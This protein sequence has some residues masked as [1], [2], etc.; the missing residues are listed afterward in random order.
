MKSFWSAELDELK[1]ASINAHNLWVLYDTPRQGIINKIYDA[2]Y[3]YK[4]AI[5]HASMNESL[6][7]DDELSNHFLRK[8]MT[9][10]WRHWYTRFSKRNARPTKC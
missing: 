3:K 9:K 1:Q 10:F 2:K 4:S 8:D 7:F 6:E 5:K